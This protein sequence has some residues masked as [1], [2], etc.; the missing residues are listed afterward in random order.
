MRR[1]RARCCSA[2]RPGRPRG[3]AAAAVGV[4][5]R[6]RPADAAY[7]FGVFAMSWDLL[8]GFA[9]EVNFGPTLPDRPRRLHRRPCSTT[10][11]GLADP[12]LRRP[13]ARSPRVDRRR[14]C[15]RCRRCGCAAPISAWSRWS[16][17][18][19]CRTSIVIFAGVTGG[20]IGLT[21]PDVLSVDARRQLLVRAGLHGS[22][23]AAI[24]FGLSRSAV[25]LILQASG[26]DAI[27]AAALGFNVTK[28]KL[29]A[30]CD[31]RVLLRPRRR[32]ADL[33]PGHRL[34]RHRRRHRGR[35]A[36]HHRRRARRPAHHP[37]RRARRGVP[38]RSPAKSCG[39]S[40]SSTPSWSRPSRWR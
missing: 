23:A 2:R 32:A 4:G 30:F 19:C 26:Q 18:C 28:H 16:R 20:E 34:G 31:Q 10:T 36:D 24:L 21:V 8:F 22:S 29:A 38:D 6:A 27:E 37:R 35:R 15:W 25:G 12:G 3:G 33:L 17:C 9:G 40:A 39:R 7:Y 13:R 14:R 1:A 11:Y 5:L